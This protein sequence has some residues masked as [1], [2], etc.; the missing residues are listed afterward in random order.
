MWASD[1]FKTCAKKNCTFVAEASARRSVELMSG[2]RRMKA[3]RRL[4][5]PYG[6]CP[7]SSCLDPWK[8]DEE[9]E[10]PLFDDKSV[11]EGFQNRDRQSTNR[12]VLWQLKTDG[13]Q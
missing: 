13:L 4:Q 12:Q 6:P 5:P 10:G 9:D 7:L 11:E 1:G 8:G 3:L 2:R